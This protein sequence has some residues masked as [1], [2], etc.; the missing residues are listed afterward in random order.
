MR[1]LSRRRFLGATAAAAA[2]LLIPEALGKLFQR[3]AEAGSAEGYGPLLLD[4]AGMLDLPAGFSYTMLST[5]VL[6]K[7]NDRRFSQKLG[8]GEPVPPLHDGMASFRGLPEVTVLVRNHELRPG[9]SPRVD[10]ARHRPYDRLAGGGTTTLWVDA[11]RHVVRSFPSLSGTLRNCAGG[12][13]PWGSYLTCEECTY[14]PG[15]ADPHNHDLTPDVG[16][17][18]GYVFE[19]DS[20]AEGLVDPVPL[21]A[22]GRFYHEA[23]AVDPETGFVYL[24]E[25]REDGLI[26]R[27]RPSVVTRGIKKPSQLAVGDLAKGGTLEALTIF[28]LSRARTQNWD[29]RRF[30]IGRQ[31]PVKWVAIPNV[32]PDMDME[33][34]PTD[35]NPIALMRRPRTAPTSTRAQGFKL[36]AA[37]F[38]RVEGMIYHKGSIYFCAT[39]GGL[40]RAGQVWRLNPERRRLTLI[41]EPDD[42]SQLD[43]PDNLVAAPNGD[44]VVCEDGEG[45]NH[46]VGITPKGGIYP[47]ARNALNQS[48]L[49]GACFSVDGRT[50][51]VNVQQPGITFAIQGPWRR[52]A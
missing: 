24:S 52:E 37:Q 43:G 9:D 39:D 50:L 4:P 19:V 11:Q 16:E 40:K 41:V 22:M 15:P 6:G 17:R 14:L 23:V 44:L 34:D 46:V 3:A 25:D 13:T 36:G 29:K 42:R 30:P 32:D 8:N 20:R 26:Y 35:P 45:S 1:R 49:A 38:A 48:E 33:R 10:E 12:P 51:F 18:H 28:T 2:G 27:F 7:T 31:Y 47:L 21:K 5:A